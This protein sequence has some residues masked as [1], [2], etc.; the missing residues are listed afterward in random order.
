MFY[1][2]VYKFTGTA[3]AHVE[4]ETEQDAIDHFHASN[5]EVSGDFDQRDILEINQQ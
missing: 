4:A 1:K 2:I 3:T 5:F